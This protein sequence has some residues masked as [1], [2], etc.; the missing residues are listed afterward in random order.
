VFDGRPA[1]H[2]T[3]ARHLGA[4][5]GDDD[6]LRRFRAAM[7]ISVDAILLID[8]ASLRYVDRQPHVLRN[9]GLYAVRKCLA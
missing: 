4:Q 3:V 7:D 1:A 5:A 2:V 9:A 6:E 8:R